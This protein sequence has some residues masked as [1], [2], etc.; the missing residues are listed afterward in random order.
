MCQMDVRL[1]SFCLNASI[2]VELIKS[3]GNDSQILI[4]EGEN[5][6][7]YEST[8]VIGCWNFILQRN[9]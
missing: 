6:Y 4:A 7:K 1:A 5:E 9:E 3:F 8:L 2:F